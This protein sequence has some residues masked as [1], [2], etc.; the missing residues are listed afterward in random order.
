MSK[1]SA[2]VR[3]LFAGTAMA[4]PPENDEDVAAP[5]ADAGKPAAAGPSPAKVE[6]ALV[7]ATAAATKAES[8]RWNQ[9]MSSDAGAANPKGAARLLTMANGASS[10]DEVIAA[11]GDITPPAAA[12]PGAAAAARNAADAA[13]LAA[14]PEAKPDTGAAGGSPEQRRGEGDD[15]SAIKEKRAARHKQRNAAAEKRGGKLANAVTAV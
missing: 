13:A 10:A 11:L 2:S 14:D 9:V 7:E 12:A 4:S 5:G 6:A 8:D 3:N 15:R 1:F